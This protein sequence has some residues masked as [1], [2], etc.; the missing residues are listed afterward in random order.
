MAE[1]AAK[2]AAASARRCVPPDVPGLS[3]QLNLTG[4][5]A[6]TG[7]GP[8]SSQRAS[9]EALLAGRAAVPQPHFP[10]DGTE[11]HL[12]G[13]QNRHRVQRTGR[14]NNTQGSP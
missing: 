12:C 9:A 10:G 1:T 5:A 2:A 11:H 13:A 14:F 6:A 3:C 7:S 8:F 4:P